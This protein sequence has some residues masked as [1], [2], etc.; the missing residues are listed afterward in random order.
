MT[1]SGCMQEIA[2]V[3]A[4]QELL[5]LLGRGN[6]DQRLRVGEEGAVAT[7]GAG[8]H[9]AGVFRHAVGDEGG[10][11]ALLAAINPGQKP[12]QVADG[13]SVVVFG[14]ESA[15]IVQRAVAHHGDHRHA[16]RRGDR[17]GFHGIHP[18]HAA[19]AAENAGAANG[20]MF[21]DFKL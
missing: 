16:Q 6:L 11:E 12:T 8:H 13:K 3:V 21:D 10:V 17:E 19:A 5:D 15:G 20:G 18:A 7:D 1:L 4:G 9:H 2:A 14:T